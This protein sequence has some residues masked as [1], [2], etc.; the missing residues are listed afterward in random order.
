MQPNERARARASDAPAEEIG[1]GSDDRIAQAEA[2]LEDSD[3][4]QEARE[5]SG[6]DVEHRTP[7]GDR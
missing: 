6:D 5:E 1:Q 3:Q 4:R 7:A 2:I